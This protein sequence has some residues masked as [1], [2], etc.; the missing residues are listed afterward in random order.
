MRLAPPSIPQ[1]QSAGEAL[2]PSDTGTVRDHSGT[3]SAA[4][5]T[6]RELIDQTAAARPNAVFLISPETGTTIC[7]G[8]LQTAS[9]LISA[10][11]RDLGLTRGDTVAFALDNGLFTVQLMLGSMYGGFVPVPLNLRAGPDNLAYVLDHC[12]ARFAFVSE[13]CRPLLDQVVAL[14]RRPFGLLSTDI[15]QIVLSGGMQPEPFTGPGPQPAGRA[16]LIYTSGS[17]GRP[18]GVVHSHRSVLAAAENSARAHE[19]TAEDCSLLGL[20]LYHINAECVTVMP[21][22]ARGG[23]VV[24]PN[25][26]SAHQFWGRMHAHRCTWSALVPTHVAQLLDGANPAAA[27]WDEIRGHIRFLR[28]SSGPLSPATQRGF[29][30][31]FKV[32]LLQAMG[33]TEAGNVFSNP[34]PPTANKVGSVGL[35]WGSRVRI[36]DQDGVDVR[37]GDPGEILVQGPSVM[38]GYHKDP[39][40]TAAAMDA[41]GWWH[42]GD[43]ARQ[44]EDGYFFVVG[45]SKEL[46][47]KGGVN[48][49]PREIATTLEDHPAVLEA[50]ALGVP[51]P[52][53]GEDIHAF[54]A[55]RPNA[56][57]S[58]RELL[59]H[60]EDRLGI[61][62][63]PS[64]I[65]FLPELPK[66]PSGKVQP[67]RLRAQVRKESITDD[68]FWRNDVVERDPHSEPGSKPTPIETFITD[69]WSRLL[70][71]EKVGLDSNF[72]ALGGHSLLAMQSLSQVRHRLPILLS[73]S[74]FFA[75]PTIAQL[76]SV[77][78]SRLLRSHSSHG[79]ASAAAR[80]TLTEEDLL[81]EGALGRA[82]ATIPH[83][84]QSRHYPLTRRQVPLWI[85]G[86]IDPEAPV[87][88]ESEAVRLYGDLR[89]D[90]LE[91][92]YQSVV[93]RHEVLRTTIQ[94][95]DEGP[96]ATVQDGL[97]SDFRRIDLVDAA[98]QRGE[99]GL[100]RLLAH[101]AR[102]PFEL[103]TKSGIRATVIRL[104]PREHVLLLMMHHVISDRFSFG[105]VW[106]EMAA[107]YAA[108]SRGQ[109]ISLPPLPIQF[110]DYAVWRAGQ[111]D[112]PNARAALAYWKN[113]L[114]GAPAFIDLPTDRPRPEMG[115]SHGAKRW[116]QIDAGLAEDLR[117][118]S[119]REHSSLFSLFAAAF[120]VL[121]HRLSR[122]H[123]LVVGIP[124]ADR[125]LPELQPMIG[126]LVDTHALRIN[127]R[128][129]PEF[130]EV[131][132]RVRRG[133][134]DLASNREVSFADVFEAIGGKR[135]RSRAPI[136]QVTMNW[137]DRDA[138]LCF[139][140]LE[141]VVVEPVQVETGI[142]K[143]D[144]CLVLTDTGSG[145]EIW[146]E[147]AYQTALFDLV[148]VE[149]MADDLRRL[150][151]DVA[152]DPDL[153]VSRLGGTH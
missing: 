142:S 37:R 79:E 21:S 62:T 84:P 38:I 66:G 6:V 25:R 12:D 49:S 135:D 137:R 52:Y 57:A 23:S 83:S 91:K 114:D 75:N 122:Q 63:T 131:L 86:Q 55:L 106:R 65:E 146:L 41:E 121:L 40:A 130:R 115:S 14:L 45:R 5:E 3:N 69:I 28:S 94:L 42:S 77:I 133:L 26:F 1:L 68:A 111:A 100:D 24:V 60:C 112:Q 124:I 29:L 129:D 39:Q 93:D 134:S 32:P 74:D 36:V 102:R 19:L 4:I 153:P 151:G 10:R 43:L 2:S 150:L 139:I 117:E 9:L 58:E 123:D 95:E 73:L 116:F 82:T 152:S 126:Y 22:L 67:L 17:T 147:V 87:Y 88:N 80:A 107:I 125:E 64:R 59:D 85:L 8:E 97:T 136:F 140:G 110:G 113:T 143:F 51:D 149:R 18:K 138:Q 46:I 47:I 35:P 30:D 31:R 105:I 34:T 20:P 70:G 119:R 132:R 16:L 98:G 11:L 33:S 71:L 108:V 104:A 109:S 15:D 148:R 96:V 145:G 76:A 78:R 101:E 141:G 72:F 44:D 144:L 89:V 99:H 92:A 48:I 54:V 90:S 50:A 27:V 81:T 61:F 118:L 53:L 7:F 127:V 13:E 120:L 103:E 56:N 128:G